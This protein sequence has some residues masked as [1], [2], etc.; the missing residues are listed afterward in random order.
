MDAPW[1]TTALAAEEEGILGRLRTRRRRCQLHTCS[2]M[3]G[4][5]LIRLPHALPLLPHFTSHPPMGRLALPQGE[6]G[7]RAWTDCT[8]LRVDQSLMR[9]HRSDMN[10]LRRSEMRPQTVERRELRMR[11]GGGSVRLVN[12]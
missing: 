3:L 2:A 7:K 11:I 4:L 1:L 10:T 9:S 6:A 8:Q 12:P 5:F